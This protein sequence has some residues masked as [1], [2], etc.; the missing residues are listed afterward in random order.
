M[1][2]PL[3][4]KIDVFK[5]IEVDLEPQLETKKPKR[6]PNDDYD[7]EDPFIEQLENE[8]EAVELEC[9]LSSFFIYSGKMPFD[10]QKV[11]KKYENEVKK[12]GTKDRKKRKDIIKEECTVKR[13]KIMEEIKE[14]TTELE[15]KFLEIFLLQLII[16]N[17]DVNTFLQEM[18]EL[19]KDINEKWIDKEYLKLKSK[20]IQCEFERYKNEITSLIGLKCHK[21]TDDLPVCKKD[22]FNS[23]FYDMVVIFIDLSFKLLYLESYLNETKRI[24]EDVAKKR[25]Y[26]DLYK[27]FP[28]GCDCYKSLGYNIFRYKQR[29]KSDK[30]TDTDTE[31]MTSIIGSL[32]K[33]S[34]TKDSEFFDTQIIENINTEETFETQDDEK[35]I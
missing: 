27:I 35:P 18:K 33:D 5:S 23:V 2:F 21:H 9:N 25:I 12:A 4:I 32:D 13:C 8:Y 19:N 14:G 6:R 1:N 16:E 29:K 31:M 7:Y 30:T 34:L 28:E 26:N 20:E 15:N 3:D 22:L 11:I 10:R 24:T 17:V